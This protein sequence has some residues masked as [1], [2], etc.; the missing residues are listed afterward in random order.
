MSE[1]VTV[2]LKLTAGLWTRKIKIPKIHV[3]GRPYRIPL[4]PALNLSATNELQPVAHHLRT[5]PVLVFEH[6][7]EVQQGIYVLTLT[8]TENF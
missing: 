5:T 4:N 7:G 6:M 8:R 2:Q 3:L 1:F